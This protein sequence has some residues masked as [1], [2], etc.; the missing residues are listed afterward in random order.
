MSLEI[1]HSYIFHPPIGLHHL[2][3]TTTMI[4]QKFIV[5]A[6]YTIISSM[7]CLTHY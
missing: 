3:A 1:T 2:L 6:N 7:K 4:F 5:I